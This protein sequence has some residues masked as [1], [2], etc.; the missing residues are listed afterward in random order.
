MAPDRQ[1]SPN[2]PADGSV[3][4]KASSGARR[5]QSMPGTSSLF[6]WASQATTMHNGTCALTELRMGLLGV[7]LHF[8][9]RR[10]FR[11]RSCFGSQQCERVKVRKVN[12]PPRSGGRKTLVAHQLSPSFPPFCFKG[13]DCACRGND[14]SVGRK[15]NSLFAVFTIEF[16]LIY[17]RQKFVARK[18]LL[19]AF[20]SSLVW[21]A[22]CSFALSCLGCMKGKA[23]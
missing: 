6:Q 20:I 18:L 22:A 19:D 7:R 17:T 1:Q 12:A 8:P 10:R 9:S 21:L 3:A 11:G 2:T 23:F 15:V 14:A 5:C 4:S 13:K 16:L